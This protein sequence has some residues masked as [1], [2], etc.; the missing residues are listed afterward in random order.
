M[1]LETK[2]TVFGDP[3]RLDIEWV[4]GTRGK[5]FFS[6]WTEN[7]VCLFNSLV[8]CMF[9]GATQFLMV[10]F[11]PSTYAEMMNKI[12][13]WGVTPSGLMRVGE[14]VFNLQRLFNHRLKGWDAQHDRF[15]DK[16]AYEPATM[17]LFKGKK[18]PWN[19]TLKEYYHIRGWTEN[20]LPTPE[21]IRELG[22]EDA[23]DSLGLPSE[24]K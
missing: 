13:G 23:M 20:G 22:L 15:A 10:G 17:G 24:S 5:A 9:G 1:P 14:R 19:S 4:K 7:F 21:K 6:I 8:T 2:K 12:T 11:G 3:P 18:V 16:K